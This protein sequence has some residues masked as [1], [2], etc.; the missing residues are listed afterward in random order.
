MGDVIMVT[1][2]ITKQ[3]ADV[4]AKAF[5][6]IVFGAAA[7]AIVG[8]AVFVFKDTDF[9]ENGFIEKKMK[10]IRNILT[11]TP[12]SLKKEREIFSGRITNAQNN[13]NIYKTKHEVLLRGI[14]EE[15]NKIN[16]NKVI[17]KDCVLKKLADALTVIGVNSEMRDYPL[18]VLDY[19][20]FP[21]NDECNIITKQYEYLM[22]SGEEIKDFYFALAPTIFVLKYLRELKRNHKKSEDFKQKA[23]SVLDKMKNDLERMETLKVALNNISNIFNELKNT[24]I[25]FIEDFISEINREYSSYEEIPKDFLIF[26]KNCVNILKDICEKKIVNNKNLESIKEYSDELSIKYCE[27]NKLFLNA[28]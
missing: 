11:G 6:P 15:I 24:Y 8:V 19:R 27:I 23:N 28:A 9:P 1:N 13:F 20:D 12:N 17:I 3:M 2:N 21:I 7:K 16:K 14:Q 10:T 18:E 4:A 26:I 5:V 25:P 22:K